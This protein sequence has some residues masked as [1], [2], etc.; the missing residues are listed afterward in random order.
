M[1]LF[2]IQFLGVHRTKYVYVFILL[3]L[4][5]YIGT[6]EARRG[7]HIQTLLCLDKV[8]AMNFGEVALGL[9]FQ[10]DTCGTVGFVADNQVNLAAILINSI[11]HHVD[12]LI[13]GEDDNAASILII[14]LQLA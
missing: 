6:I 9:V 5:F 7:S 4:H 14:L 12:T 10:N 8:V 11:F 13:G 1:E 2:A 3:G